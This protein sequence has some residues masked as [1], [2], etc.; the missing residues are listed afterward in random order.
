M[1]RASTDAPPTAVVLVGGLGTRLRP[2]VRDRPKPMAS[3]AGSPF[4]LRILE[5]VRA[6]GIGELV[7]STGHLGEQIQ[8]SLG[9]AYRGLSLRYSREDTPMGTG[10]ALRLALPL[11]Q[12]EQALVMNGDSYCGC[13][14]E[15]LQRFHAERRARIT[16]LL[17]AVADTRRFGRVELDASRRIRQFEEK[18][19]TRGRGLINAGVYLIERSL[20]GEIPEGRPLSLERDV[21]PSWIGAGL[22]GFETQGPFID[23]GTPETY[24]EAERFFA[25][26]VAGAERP[27]QE[28]RPTA[29][30]GGGYAGASRQPS[31]QRHPSTWS[32]AQS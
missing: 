2:V 28:E 16:M 15:Q 1:Q 6:W 13:R 27:P 30:G 24:A 3:I 19:T 8:A 32:A 18:G 14:F 22:Y 11:I 23:I 31:R 4:L 25:D 10:G 21:F 7:L 12:T 9:S 5:Q 29:T 17:T 26:L 20:I